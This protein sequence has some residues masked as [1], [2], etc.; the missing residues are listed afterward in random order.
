MVDEGDA[1]NE[2]L[3]NKTINNLKAL[4]F[5]NKVDSKI[6]KGRSPSKK[7][8]SECLPNPD[9]LNLANRTWL[10]FTATLYKCS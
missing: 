2:L 8:I 7:I 6:L 4:N 10:Q 1:F 5:F 3:H 9:T